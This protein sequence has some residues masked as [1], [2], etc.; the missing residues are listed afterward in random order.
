MR[1]GATATRGP[2]TVEICAHFPDGTVH[3]EIMAATVQAVGR[4]SLTLIEN[5]ITP[6]PGWTEGLNE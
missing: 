5:E 6:P 1:L 4:L 2:V 3:D